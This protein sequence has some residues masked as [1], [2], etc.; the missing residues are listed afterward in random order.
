M[1]YFV[2]TSDFVHSCKRPSVLEFS[3]FQLG[4]ILI[5]QKHVK[6]KT[7]YIFLIT[8]VVV[9]LRLVLF[10]MD[11]FEWPWQYNFPPFFT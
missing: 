8:D 5:L 1:S 6:Q 7:D 9:R 2:F 11:T 4:E 10:I 3:N